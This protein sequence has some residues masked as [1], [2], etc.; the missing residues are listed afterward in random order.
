M[1]KLNTTVDA[2]KMSCS[3]LTVDAMYNPQNNSITIPAGILQKPMYDMN[4]SKEQNYGGIGTVIGHEIS[5]AFDNS[6]CRFDSDGNLADWWTQDDYSKFKEKTQK[7]S[8]F[9]SKIKTDN[10]DSVNGDLT[11]G[12]NIADIS[13]V[14]Y[15]LDIVK[16]IDTPNLNIIV[17]E[18][19]YIQFG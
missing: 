6:G 12:E 13:G 14:A 5:H 16:S 15:C 19:G 11:V 3:P 7:V 10:G 4:A 8:D 9:Y 1:K 2:D 18:Y 17:F